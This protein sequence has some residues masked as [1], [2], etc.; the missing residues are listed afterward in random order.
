MKRIKSLIKNIW[1]TPEDMEKHIEID[2]DNQIIK[3]KKTGRI[4]RPFITGSRK[5]NNTYYS[6]HILKNKKRYGIKVHLI[7]FYAKHRY[8]PEQVDHID[9]NKHNNHISNLR[10]CT[11]QLNSFNKEKIK[12]RNNKPLSSK[13]KSVYFHNKQKKWIARIRLNNQLKTLGSFVEEDMAG[14]AVNQFYINNNLTEFA[15]FNDTP[16]ERLRKL[17]KFDSLPEEMQN[18]KALFKNINF[19][20]D[21]K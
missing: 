16:Q 15:V 13:Y 2:L 8:I 5:K 11:R 19:V 9:R 6:I 21:I 12:L 4:L 14:E 17:N 10:P 3:N 1:P 7:Y 20:G 18:L